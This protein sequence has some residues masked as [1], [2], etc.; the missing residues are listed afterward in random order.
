M[1]LIPES[2]MYSL[3]MTMLFALSGDLHAVKNR[4]V[5]STVPNTISEFIQRL[6][7]RQPLQRPNPQVED[8]TQTMADIRTATF[9][10]R[11]SGMKP[12]QHRPTAARS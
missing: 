2:D 9:G 1:V 10:R 11:R 12:I 6:V 7:R 8:L 4:E 5:P 3:G